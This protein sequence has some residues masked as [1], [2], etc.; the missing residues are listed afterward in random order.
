MKKGEKLQRCGI[1][2]KKIIAPFVLLHP[3]NKLYRWN[4]AHK[5]CIDNKSKVVIK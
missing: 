4:W 3:V 1:C 2:L 5:E